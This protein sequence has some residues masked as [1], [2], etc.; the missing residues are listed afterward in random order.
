ML[1]TLK[2]LSK[3]RRSKSCNWL[4]ELATDE[5]YQR[6]ESS[7]DSDLNF[8]NPYYTEVTAREI[9]HVDCKPRKKRARKPEVLPS[10]IYLTTEEM[11]RQYGYDQSLTT[12]SSNAAG[13][14]KLEYDLIINALVEFL[15]TRSQFPTHAPNCS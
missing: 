8:T 14:P 3:F 7:Q 6:S 13:D 12:R 1:M 9:T 10:W 15:R 5:S 2:L 11:L 4:T